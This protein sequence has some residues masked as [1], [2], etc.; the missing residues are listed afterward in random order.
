MI[1]TEKNA[2]DQ[3]LTYTGDVHA[4]VN[5]GLQAVKQQNESL[6]NVSH[7]D[8]RTRVAEFE[9]VLT[10]QQASLEARLTALGGKATNPVKDA[11]SATL[12]AAAGLINKAR[13]SETCKS[14]RDDYTF[15]SHLAVRL[16]NAP[17]HG[18]GARR[19]R[20]GLPSR[21]TGYGRDGASRD[22]HRPHPAEDRRRGAPRRQDAPPGGRADRDPGDDQGRVEPRGER[23]VV[24][25]NDG[26]S[27]LRSGTEVFRDL[28]PDSFVRST[29]CPVRSASS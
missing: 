7:V 12:G 14:I 21:R 11:V 26:R 13:A 24:Q 23:A 29:S 6:K 5:H 4:L 19:S 25:L 15:M 17:H 20:H 3:I 1:P 8:A 22:A 16:A 27:L 10:G 2:L 18:A 28:G 9:R